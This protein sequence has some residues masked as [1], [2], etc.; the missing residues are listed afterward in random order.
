M[1]TQTE[2]PTSSQ[3]VA[4]QMVLLTLGLA[5]LIAFAWYLAF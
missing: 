5:I 3:S 2:N 1:T 4:G